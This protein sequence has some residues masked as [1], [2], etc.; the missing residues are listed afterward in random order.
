MNCRI[1]SFGAIQVG[2]LKKYPS[3]EYHCKSTIE[4]RFIA[5]EVKISNIMFMYMDA[6]HQQK[7]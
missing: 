4:N 5:A 2:R 1:A 7:L 3:Y 6:V